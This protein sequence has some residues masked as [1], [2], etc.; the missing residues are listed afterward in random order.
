MS[1]WYLFL[2]EYSSFKKSR[3]FIEREEDFV[4]PFGLNI[5][6]ICMS[7]CGWRLNWYWS[8]VCQS[9]NVT[10]FI[11]GTVGDCRSIALQQKFI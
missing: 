5:I 8:P 11:L 9:V 7:E 2:H 4:A 10:I 1:I 6:Q 3:Q